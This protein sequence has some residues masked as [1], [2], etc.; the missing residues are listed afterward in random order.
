MLQETISDP[1]LVFRDARKKRA[2][3][4]RVLINFER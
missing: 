1:S 3:G 2:E 4:E